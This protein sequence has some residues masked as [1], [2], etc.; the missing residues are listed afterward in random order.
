[1]FFHW[2]APAL[3][4]TLTEKKHGTQSIGISCGGRTTKIHLVAAND[5]AAIIFSL[6]GG[7]KHDAP[8]GRKLIEQLKPSEPC[9]LIMDK[10][11]K[12]ERWQVFS[13][14]STKEQ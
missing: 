3:K 9:S 2:I 8:Q 4:C 5:R 14:C 12:Q 13:S 7:E 11:T 1:M 6:S 10:M